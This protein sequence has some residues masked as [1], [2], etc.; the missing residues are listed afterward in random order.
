MFPLPPS[1]NK[2]IKSLHVYLIFSNEYF[3]GTIIISREQMK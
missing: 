3:K 2:K 1:G